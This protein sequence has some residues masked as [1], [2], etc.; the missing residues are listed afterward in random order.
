[1]TCAR[2]E[3]TTVCSTCGS[4]IRA[5]APGGQCAKCLLGLGHA[6][7]GDDAG[8]D[9]CS[10]N[11]GELL[12][13]SQVRHFGDYELIEEI[14][15][16]GMGVVYRAL[17]IS[18]NRPVALKMILAGQLATPDSV[19]RFR[20]EAKAAAKLDHPHIVPIY[21]VGEHETQN[22][23]TMKLVEGGSLAERIE[24]F[25][26]R[27]SDLRSGGRLA[28][29]ERQLRIAALMTKVADAL[30]YAHAH[31]VL[32]RDLKPNNILLDRDGEPL[33]T[34][35][36]LAKLIA[37]S[38][39]LTLSTAV[40][41][42]PSYMAPEQ[43]AGN[44]RDVTTA[45]DVYG[46]GAVLYEL[47]T[48]QPP[49][50]GENAVQTMRKVLDE[51]PIPPSQLNPAVSRD[52]E[53][54][55]L[56]CLEKEPERRY[57]SARAVVEE[58]E[59]FQRGEPIQARPV[60]RAEQ[61][62]RWCKRKPAIAG[63]SAAAAL[64]VVIGLAGVVWQW[65][66]AEFSRKETQQSNQ[67]LRRTLDHL[68]WRNIN[69]VLEQD[70]AGRAVAHL[71]DH[72]RKD[73]A[74]WQAATYAMSI[75]EQRAFAMPTGIEIVHR[76]GLAPALPV[77]SAD[78][79]LLAIAGHDRAVRVHNAVTGQEAFAPLPHESDV[80]ALVFTADGA[81]LATATRDGPVNF[82]DARSGQLRQRLA[83]QS[84]PLRELV[85]SQD[86]Q[87]LAVAGG[88]VVEVWRTADA[89]AGRS[90]LATLQHS[91]PVDHVRLSRDGGRVLTWSA[92]NNQPLTVWDAATG[93]RLFAPTNGGE[94]RW[95]AL[96][97][98]GARVAA[99]VGDYEVA[100]WDTTS[101]RQAG[102][103]K[104]DGSP[105]DRL[106][107]TPDGERAVL[108]F[109]VGMARVFSVASGLPVSK[110]MR[111]LYN[112]HS[113]ALEESGQR[114][115]TGSQDHG[116]RVWNLVTGEPLCEPM[117][118]SGPVVHV[119][120]AARAE[121]VLTVASDPGRPS[122]RVYA[123]NLRRS[124][125]PLRFQPPGARDL[126]MVRLSPD[127]KLVVVPAFTPKRA[128]WIY[129]AATQ[130]LVF[131]PEEIRGDVYGIE[132]TPDMKRL[133]VATAN[134][135]LYGWSVGDWRPLWE[136]VQ[137]PGAIQPTA[138]S[139]DG[140]IFA[141]GGPDGFVRLWE[142]QTGRLLREM[143]HGALVKGL[144]FSPNGDRIIAGSGDGIG[145][146]WDAQT[147]ARRATLTGHN[148][149]I[150]SVEFS[151]DGRR[152]VTASY[153][154]TVRLWDVA[155]GHQIAP[156]LQQ[157]GEASHASFSPD[158]RRV[159]T[160]ARD[161]TARIWDAQTGQPL[162][163]WMR[164][165][166]TVQT[167]EF[168]PDGRRLVT[169]DHAGFRLWDVETGEPITLHYADRVSGGVGV[170]S[171]SVR[172]TFSRD[173][174]RIFLGC[175]TDAATLWDIP[176]PPPGAPAWFPDFLEAVAGQRVGKAGEYLPVPVG[177]F[178]ELRERAASFGA[179]DYYEAWARW[180]L[181]FATERP[182]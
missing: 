75:L 7:L 16:G 1:M 145:I 38:S 30:A 20:L 103:I 104:S 48:G 156:P 102:L 128:V 46:I 31:G 29:R 42:S 120:F 41:G 90:P 13:K 47:I 45:A 27:A 140:T 64:A 177:K 50:I 54:I 89:L 111:H 170:D 11:G 33:L 178:L 82:W 63:L 115:V 97:A 164:H 107:L 167:V 141:T 93:A 109:R 24:D 14:A 94:T 73:P 106:A 136:P 44:T 134:G 166:E 39:G 124:V 132:F 147:G 83:T 176:N 77:I 51:E 135:W 157:Q 174:K 163:D 85:F 125:A 112:I 169:R 66:R 67:N 121:R 15:R 180:Y 23:F 78:G 88:T 71:A 122:R 116:A 58:L 17:Q 35:F 98:A 49:F 162:V 123:W 139:P 55:C 40:L 32:H 152:A 137:T 6:T 146:I 56:K 69:T 26:F 133:V 126:N 8:F 76:E 171:P 95:A 149:E 74:N 101:G 160:A 99:I 117:P 105:L 34:D 92:Q 68:E 158:G 182:R 43:A 96:D 25:G 28:L 168:H 36:G 154:S 181:G 80:V 159:A 110:W 79:A 148:A 57:R 87:A 4:T 173:G 61:I 179:K 129:D 19:A 155:T 91:F 144:R 70:Y 84:N 10:D 131:G 118:H 130:R 127:G 65:R 100:V 21:E 62:W 175:S 143:K 72:L 2:A 142:T 5:N 18:L 108:G 151:P 161:G 113:M 53:T 22:Y 165:E 3:M 150:L 138:M 119:A 81:L 153:D 9:G 60:S 52:L 59:R 37:G 12:N 172:E 86:G 114:M